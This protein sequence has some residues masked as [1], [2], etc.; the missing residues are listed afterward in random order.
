M[1][2]IER[3]SR[4]A[5][6]AARQGDQF[7]LVLAAIQAAQQ[8]Q[9]AP[10]RQPPPAPRGAAGKW[11][12]LGVAGTFLAMALAVSMVAFAIGA[13]SLTVCLLVLRSVFTQI[14]KEK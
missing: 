4:E 10:P 13:V 6:D 3:A 14:S 2:E 5:V 1:S 7:A 9:T 11:V 8:P 12:A